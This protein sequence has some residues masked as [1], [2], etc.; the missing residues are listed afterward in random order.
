MAQR[1]Q[2]KLAIDELTKLPL[3]HKWYVKLA[4]NFKIIKKSLD[5]NDWETF[6]RQVD[7]LEKEVNQLLI[8]PEQLETFKN[9]LWREVRAIVLPDLS[10]LQIT[11]EVLAFR[12]DSQGSQQASMSARLM[13]E[14]NYLKGSAA[15]WQRP[16]T[17][18]DAGHISTD[19][20]ALSRVIKNAKHIGVLGDS[21]AH[22]HL[23][24]TNFSDLL[25]RI[26]GAT[27][28]NVAVNGAHMMNNSDTSIY[29]QSK[30]IS[31]CDL[32]VIQGTDDDWLA[33]APIGT[34][35]DDEKTSYIGAFYRVVDNVR[36]L[37]PQ[38]KIIVMTAT[39]QVPVR[40]TTI[41]RTDR[42]KNELG[43][44]L[45]DYMDAQKLACTDLGLPYADFMQP[46]L[47]QPLNPAFRKKMMSEGL[48]PNDVG[49]QVI[50]QEL[51]KQIYYFYG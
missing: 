50:A 5:D 29:T 24:N 3:D 33:N 6:K 39:L 38:A 9:E 47:F 13:A 19:Y 20:L 15:V 42:T 7:K 14:I 11:Q 31:G 23:A 34:P 2:D 30:Q 32:V 36:V 21:V 10:P 16:I 22:G 43:K 18:D 45:H 35:K 28:N 49:H 46:N 26:S 48:H 40:G 41:R 44:D 8:Q 17:V 37:N 27:I 51:A 1:Q 12:T 4:N 25:Q